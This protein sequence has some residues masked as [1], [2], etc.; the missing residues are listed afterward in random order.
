MSNQSSSATESATQNEKLGMLQE[1]IVASATSTNS[2]EVDTLRTCQ[3]QHGYG[4]N[5]GSSP[6]NIFMEVLKCR[7]DDLQASFGSKSSFASP[8]SAGNAHAALIQDFN[9]SSKVWKFSL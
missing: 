3:R 5:Q 7:V 1:C 9:M 2:S 8:S 6:M 4:S